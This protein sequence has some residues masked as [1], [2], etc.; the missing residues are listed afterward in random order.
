[1]GLNQESLDAL[2]RDAAERALAKSGEAEAALGASYQQGLRAA[3]TGGDATLTGTA[4]YGDFLRLQREA[5]AMRRPR[6][7]MSPEELAARGAMPGV[8]LPNLR[9]RA[10]QFQSNVNARARDMATD[11]Q[12]RAGMART[13]QEARDEQA[14]R[15]AEAEAKMGPEWK[16]R[17]R[18]RRASTATQRSFAAM[19]SR[20]Q[21]PNQVRTISTEEYDSYSR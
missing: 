4:S 10:T 11:R 6:S 18:Y 21:N 7:G 2:E 16:D 15:F 13:A 19:G 14:R 17:E 8:D 5:E 9:Q 1:L 3:E 20:R 12:T